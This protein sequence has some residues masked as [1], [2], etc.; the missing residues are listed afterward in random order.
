M[1]KK[2]GKTVRITLVKSPIGNTQRHKDTVRAFIVMAEADNN[3]GKVVNI[4]NGK[5]IS[6]GALVEKI[7]KV[8][9]KPL[10]VE[11]DTMRFRPKKAR[12]PPS[13]FSLKYFMNAWKPTS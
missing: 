3:L 9:D 1:A 11:T 12:R 2:K 7:A 5:E 6:I 4:G 13:A 10:N 8:I